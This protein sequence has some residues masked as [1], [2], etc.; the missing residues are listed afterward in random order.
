MVPKTQNKC[1]VCTDVED[2]DNEIFRCKSCKI[3][4]HRSCYGIKDEFDENWQ[5]SPCKKG[6]LKNIVCKLCLH[7]GGTLKR[8]VCG[9]W[10]HVVCALWTE[11]VVFENPDEMESIN[12]SNVSRN[13]RNKTCIYCP[14]VFAVCAPTLNANTVYIL[15][16]LR[17]PKD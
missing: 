5:C 13:K 15:H 3:S 14:K 10:C 7:S 4:V 1:S 12:I 6:S 8:T 11:G 17:K 16:A 9:Y 2:S